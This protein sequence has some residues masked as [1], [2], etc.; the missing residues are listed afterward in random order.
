[1]VR[2]V[3]A[4]FHPELLDL[5]KSVCICLHLVQCCMNVFFKG[6]YISTTDSVVASNDC[7]FFVS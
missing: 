1:M 6:R 3:I 7:H 5:K 4:S 2:F